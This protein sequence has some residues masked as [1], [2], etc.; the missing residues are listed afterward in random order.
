MRKSILL[1]ITVLLSACFD[2]L[3]FFNTSSPTNQVVAIQS[4]FHILAQRLQCINAKVEADL[5]EEHCAS[6]S[7]I[8]QKTNLD[9]LNQFLDSLTLS[10]LTETKSSEQGVEQLVQKWFN[11]VLPELEIN[12]GWDYTREIHFIG[13]RGRVATFSVITSYYTGG[14]HGIYDTQF[15]NIDL[16]DK[17]IYQL[18]DL[19]VSP[20]KLSALTQLLREKNMAR[21]NGLAITADNMENEQLQATN[22]F[23]FTINGLVFRY[24]VYTLGSYAEGEIDLILPYSQLKGIIKPELLH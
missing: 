3:P 12:Q 6:L 4:D 16:I 24:P 15:L 21:L 8:S 13:Q 5:I 10:V 22:N 1:V 2:K 17:V 11:D 23:V 7:L 18:K 19:L 9:W 14:A 20:D